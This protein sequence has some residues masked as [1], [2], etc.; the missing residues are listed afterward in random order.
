ML[1]VLEGTLS[2]I[3]RTEKHPPCQASK[4][5]SITLNRRH[6]RQKIGFL[7]HIILLQ[8]EINNCEYIHSCLALERLQN[9]W[10]T[11]D[12]LST[13]FISNFTNLTLYVNKISYNQA[14]YSDQWGCIHILCYITMLLYRNGKKLGGTN[15]LEL[16]C[17][18]VSKANI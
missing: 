10:Y 17:T 4:C 13:Y 2:E 7:K 6:K 18:Y 3:S 1:I 5:S 9:I 8:K 11:Y 14:N 12:N 15:Y 16:F